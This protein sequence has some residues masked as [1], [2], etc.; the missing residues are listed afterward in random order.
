MGNAEAYLSDFAA[1]ADALRAQGPAWLPAVRQAALDRFAQSGFPTLRNEEWL[2]TNVTPI[3]KVHFRNE[4]SGAQPTTAD[5]DARAVG[6]LGGARFVFVDGR[7]SEPLSTIEAIPSGVRAGSLAEALAADPSLESHFSPARPTD[8]ERENGVPSDTAFEALNT[9]FF[10]DGFFLHLPAEVTVEA[11]IEVVYL[12]TGDD[13][14]RVAYPRNLFIAEAGSRATVVES[15]A[16]L[17]EGRYLTNATTEVSV[18]EK[19]HLEHYKIVHESEGAYHVATQRAEQGADSHYGTWFFSFGGQMVRNEIQLSISGAN[20]ESDMNGLY[21]ADGDRHVDNHT[22][23][24]HVEPDCHSREIYKG[25]VGGKARGVFSG[26]IFVYQEAQKTDAE[27]SND[28]IL[29]SD[30]ATVNSRPRLEIYADDVRCTHGA[31]VGELNADA[32][33]YLRSRGI[34]EVEAR[35]MLIKAFASGVIDEV[36]LESLRTVLTERFVAG[37]PAE[38]TEV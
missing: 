21:V 25:V 23:I 24:H 6:G 33:F 9:A 12:S 30:T 31:T 16:A 34:P 35:T 10:T 18:A 15:Y 3:A 19:A 7:Y 26:K 14:E 5:I 1:A 17:G 38:L 13:Q 37:L 36:P 22:F 20:C 32:L 8:R 29:V 27:Q 28:A 4:A 2:Y 11:P